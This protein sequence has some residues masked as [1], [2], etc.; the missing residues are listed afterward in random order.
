[1]ASNAFVWEALRET[2]L[3]TVSA[4][5]RD[6][7]SVI[8]AYRARLLRDGREVEFVDF[9]MGGRSDPVRAP[10][11]GMRSRREV[12]QL[13]RAAKSAFWGGLLGKLVH[14]TGA[15]TC[16][17]L[18]TSL[19]I[20][21]SYIAAA[22]PSQGR[23]VTL[24]GSGQVAALAAETLAAL[25][26]DRRVDIEVGPFSATLGTV[27]DAVG[28]IDFAFVDGDHGEVSTRAYC[29][30]LLPRMRNGGVL[31]FDDIRWSDGMLRAWR[32]ISAE[33]RG[34]ALD[35]SVLGILLPT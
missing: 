33:T 29:R 28:P 34:V 13:A 12:A 31:V 15:R 1:M 20:S 32:A 14:H 21:S 2:L 5:E 7:A 18:G 3:N 35:L 8:E 6:R 27:L 16:V 25:V 30:Q 11:Q 4:A 26:P 19:G 10:P 17:E 23:L 24:E 9:G 22:L